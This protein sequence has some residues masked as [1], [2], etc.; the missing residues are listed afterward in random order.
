M[1]VF[2][3]RTGGLQTQASWA[4]A[5]PLPEPRSPRDA[6]IRVRVVARPVNALMAATRALIATEVATEVDSWI[7]SARGD[8][9]VDTGF[10]RSQMFAEIDTRGTQIRV[11][12]GN[13][14]R[15]APFTPDA[16]QIFDLGNAAMDRALDEIARNYS[17]LSSG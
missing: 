11:R 2:R 6:A 1:A 10:S 16:F 14:A 9:A 12:M 3:T 4:P 8:W 7:R 5:R 15:Y 17:R 13:E